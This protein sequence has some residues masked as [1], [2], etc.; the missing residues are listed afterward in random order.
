[1]LAESDRP[2]T[3]HPSTQSMHAETLP[4]HTPAL[5][6]AAVE[7]AASLLAAGEV[8]ALPTETV[9]GLA[10]NALDP[11]AVARIFA[12]KGRPMINPLIVHIGRPS[13]VEQVASE[14]PAHAQKLAEAFWPG[15]L[16]LVVRKAHGIPSVV[17]AGGETVG[18]RFPYHPFMPAVIRTCGF[19]L[20]A[21]SANLA[22]CL[23]PTSAQ[24]VAD[25][26]GDRIPLIVDGGSSSVGIEST[27][28]DVTGPVPRIL[29]PGMITAE[30][31][32][33]VLGGISDETTGNSKVETT[34]TAPF[35]SEPLR[36]PG[37]LARHYAPK[38]RLLVWNWKDDDD[39]WRQ[40]LREE[41]AVDHVRIVARH[42]IPSGN[43]FPHVHVIPDDPEAFARALYGE[44][45][46][47]DDSGA[48]LVVIEA[49][50]NEP[51]WEGII[52]RLTRA[53]TT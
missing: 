36:S 14:W 31:L 46:S 26:L 20:A 40:L 10:A 53:S 19:P 3:A 50:P 9:Y 15:P 25:Q 17:T 33:R 7:R 23:S 22:N 13:M 5:F 51:A 45:H 52:D 43:Q 2:S 4:T 49:P 35:P 1:M 34:E 38:A 44:L 30:D 32:R 6:A 48:K 28:V 39:L 18:I 41:V 11:K 21:P 12:I 29:R 27:V 42:V 16:T 37:Q 24:H 8:V 47:C